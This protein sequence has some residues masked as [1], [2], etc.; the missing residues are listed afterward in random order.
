MLHT[1]VSNTYHVLK[2]NVTICSVASTSVLEHGNLDKEC[3][4]WRD[5]ERETKEN[6]KSF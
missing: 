2:L 5:C 4:R 3:W 1:L 6:C